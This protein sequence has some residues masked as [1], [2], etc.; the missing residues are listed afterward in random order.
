[1]GQTY[2]ALVLYELSCVFKLT[3]EIEIIVLV[4]LSQL[5]QIKIS[6]S[7][8]LNMENYETDFK[9]NVSVLHNQEMGA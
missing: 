3:Y 5:W 4:S 8:C 9:P 2:I 7:I 1:M 6:E